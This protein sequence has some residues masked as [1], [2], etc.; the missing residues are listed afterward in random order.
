MDFD[1]V[2]AAARP[3]WKPNWKCNMQR[4][5]S[6]PYFQIFL[7]L[8]KAYDSIDRDRL[9]DILAG[10]GFGPNMLQFLHRVW[11]NAWLALR[12]M[13]YYSCPIHSA[14]GIWQGDILSPLFLNIIVD[15]VLRQWHCQVQPSVVS[16]FY[17]DDGRIAASH[18]DFVQH[19]LEVILG[20]FTQ[21]GLFPNVKKTKAMV[22]TGLHCP[23]SMSA[24][25]YK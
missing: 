3:F 15:C 19:A 22:S 4:L 20:L 11:V 13:G 9:I 16:R 7:D 17:A 14:R 21:V 8:A 23:D 1:V 6:V 18:Q 2:M 5:Q 12:Q 25:A 24:L 10:Y